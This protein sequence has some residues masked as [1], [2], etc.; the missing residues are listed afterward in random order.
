MYLYEFI[1]NKCSAKITAELSYELN[2]N[3][4]CLC[5]TKMELVFFLKIPD[6]RA[7]SDV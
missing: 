1:C 4:H 6:T 5:G 2:Y 3:Y 7:G